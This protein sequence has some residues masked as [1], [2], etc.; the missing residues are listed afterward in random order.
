MHIR[1]ISFKLSKFSEEK[2]LKSLKNLNK[3]LFNAKKY[4]NFSIQ[5]KNTSSPLQMIFKN[6]QLMCSTVTSD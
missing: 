6:T 4:M 1:R 2:L 3:S 5:R